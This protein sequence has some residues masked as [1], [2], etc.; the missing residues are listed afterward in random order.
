MLHK[1]NKF[2]KVITISK[3][4]IPFLLRLGCKRE[5]IVHIPNSI[6]EEFFT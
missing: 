3:W 1:V 5:K 2:D 6:P 4:E